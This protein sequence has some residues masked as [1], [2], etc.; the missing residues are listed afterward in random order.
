[1]T[2]EGA[3]SPLRDVHVNGSA[4]GVCYPTATTWRYTGTLWTR[5]NVFVFTDGLD[6]RTITVYW[7]AFH[8]GTLAADTTVST[9]GI[10]YAITD[11]IIVPAGLTLT[12]EP[13][14][15]LQFQANRALRVEGGRLLAE[16]SAAQPI[17]FTRQGDGYWG[18]ILL[19]RTQADN[20]IVHAVV[21][22]TREVISNPRTHGISVYGSR[23]TIAD[24]ILRY[25]DASVA[26]QTY[27]WGGYDPTIYLL[28]NEI[29]DIE[30]DAVHVTGGYA[31]IQGNHIHDIRRGVYELEGIE[32][33]HMVTP[34]LL[35]DNHIH[36]ISDDCLDLNHSSALIERNELHHCGD[37]GI[38]I[39]HPSS[40]TLVNNL[41]YNCLG[42]DWDPY[43]GTGI[44]VKDGAVSRIVNNTVAGS[45]HGI[46]LYEGHEWQGGGSATLVNCIVW[47]N[48]SALDLDALSTITVTYSD[49][50]GGWDGDGNINEDPLFRAPQI[51][52][53]RLPED[54]PC[55]DTGTPVGAP[56]EDIRGIYRPH[57]EGY[58]RGA[59]EFFEFFSCY[60]PLI[61][62]PH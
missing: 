17:V 11:D 39:G 29:Y 27:P 40:T 2:L 34:A 21:E 32:V 31:F 5:D 18:G 22:Y 48:E 9:S 56:D 52:V 45:R 43:S 15:T 25:T 59:H 16:G 55:V 33:S 4:D 7:D 8:G 57:G 53:Y 23:V 58:D 37:K 1:V 35:L 49:I 6:S 50:E 30:S 26:V 61:L 14:V 13:G 62:R 36:D 47:G 28:R 12:I 38:S 46:Y 10:P 42:K 41:I 51:G 19:D 3:C 44:A 20:R 24:S 54:S 60:L